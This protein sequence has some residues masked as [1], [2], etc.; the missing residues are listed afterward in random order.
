MHSIYRLILVLFLTSV[1]KLYSQVY[2]TIQNGNWN[3]SATWAGGSIPALG[4]TIAAGQLVV[5]NHDVAYNIPNDLNVFGELRVIGDAAK[6]D[7]LHF[8]SGRSIFIRST[9]IYRITYGA[10]LQRMFT[11]GVPNSGSFRNEGGRVVI[12]SAYIE[13]AQDWSSTGGTRVWRN[14][15][16]H[17]GQNFSNDNTTDSLINVGI[18]IG[19]HGSGTFEGKNVST[20]IYFLDSYIE[21]NGTSGGISFEKGNYSGGIDSISIKSAG[22]E[23]KTSVDVT[24]SVTLD[25]YCVNGAARY[26]D[27]DNLFTG[28]EVAGG[29]FPYD[30]NF[31]CPVLM[32]PLVPVQFKF[33]S[34]VSQGSNISIQWNCLF[35]E[36]VSYF[37]IEKSDDGKKY[38]PIGQ[39]V[40]SSANTSTSRYTF[41]DHNAG[42]G[43]KYYR[44]IKVNRGGQRYISPVVHVIGPNSRNIEVEINP[45]SK[46]IHLH[47][48]TSGILSVFVVDVTGR[49]TGQLVRTK[50]T[51]EVNI[52][53][54]P[55]GLYILHIQMEDGLKYAIKV[56]L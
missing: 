1:Q 33:I 44:V 51:A 20:N 10:H 4:G 9:G 41:L 14:G 6:I 11:S 55:R 48:P 53:K 7:T 52:S 2:T 28:P 36:D 49:K 37:I 34:A 46:T 25:W 47:S 35:I 17:T 5:I 32:S 18:G 26:L 30:L 21:V 8:P 31:S 50:N 42:S 19:Y 39:V 27:L 29:P 3:N 38:Y 43:V 15:C 24:G 16:L 54:L 13:V 12:N 56:A 40:P 45:A 22:G 23:I